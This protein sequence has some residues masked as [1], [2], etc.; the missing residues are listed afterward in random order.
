M[1]V[2]QCKPQFQPMFELCILISII[3]IHNEFKDLGLTSK[4]YP[5]EF[6]GELYLNKVIKEVH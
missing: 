5:L 1:I 6:M 2:R 4:V 3:L